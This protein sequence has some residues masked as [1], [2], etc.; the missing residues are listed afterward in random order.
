MLLPQFSG[1]QLLRKGINETGG[2]REREGER[3]SQGEIVEEGVVAGPRWGAGLR[4]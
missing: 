3:D 4:V 1:Q 2:E